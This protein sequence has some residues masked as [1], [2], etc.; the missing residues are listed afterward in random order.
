[1]QFA[2]PVASP[3]TVIS[4]A[5]HENSSIPVAAPPLNLFNH[6]TPV[7]HSHANGN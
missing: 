2:G 5:V 1:M 7:N 6:P 3:V 4:P